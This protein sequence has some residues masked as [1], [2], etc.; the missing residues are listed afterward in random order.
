M[1]FWYFLIPLIT[2]LIATTPSSFSDNSSLTEH[3]F[4]GVEQDTYTLTPEDVILVKISGIGNMPAGVDRERANITITHPDST[5]D[6][7][8]VF[9]GSDGYFE[10]LLPLSYDSQQGVYKVFASFHG[11]ILGEVYFTVE[12]ISL[13]DADTTSD[14]SNEDA[15]HVFAFRT[16]MFEVETDSLSYEKDSIIF[17]NS[18]ASARFHRCRS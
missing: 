10:L 14:S 2:L 3:G 11:H 1:N 8:R 4:F 17:L 5:E 6:G 9:S 12:R 7:H 13:N 15:K 16:S 18:M